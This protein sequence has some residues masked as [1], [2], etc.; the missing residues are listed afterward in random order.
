[1]SNSKT[2]NLK[3]IKKLLAGDHISQTKTSVSMVSPDPETGEYP[4]GHTWVDADGNEWVQKKGFKLMKS[5]T[6]RATAKQKQDTLEKKSCPKCGK[7]PLGKVDEKF[8]R[9][10]GHCLD[11]NVKYEHEL[12]LSGKL[13][14]YERDVMYNNA[15]AWLRQAEND[16]NALVDTIRKR[17]KDG[18]AFVDSSGYIEQWIENS[19]EEEV[20]NTLVADF[21]TFKQNIL[22]SFKTSEQQH[23]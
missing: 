2:D 16:L 18:L 17:N 10:R 23:E 3:Q 21:E 12:L 1:M 4:V 20:I 7:S 15:V 6:T 22:S 11:C 13:E 9:L 5:S 19:S 8:I 14:D